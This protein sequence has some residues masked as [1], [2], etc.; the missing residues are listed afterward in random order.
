MERAAHK[1]IAVVLALAPLLGLAQEPARP[2][3]KSHQGPTSGTTVR[4]VP[5]TRSAESLAAAEIAEAEAAMEK[6]DFAAAENA[7]K[8]AVGHDPKNYRAWFDYGLLYTSTERNGEAIEAY[9]KSIAQNPK[10][11]ESNFNLGVLLTR[12]NDPAAE[13]YLRAATQLTPN[14]G[15]RD[16]AWFRSWMTLGHLLETSKPREAIDAFDHAAGLNPKDVSARLYAGAIAEKTGDM[17]IAE[18]EYAAAQQINPN[19]PQ[20]SAG[21]ANVLIATGRGDQAEEAIR[22]YIA[23]L[24]KQGAN[25]E[26]A[27][28]HVELGHLLLQLHRRDEAIT[29]FE[30]A[31]KL[32]PGNVKAQHELAWMYL[33]D[34]QYAKAET[35]FRQLLQASPKDAELRAGLGESL[36]PQKKFAEAQQELIAALQIKPDMVDAYSDLAFAASE[37]K[38]YE[39]AVKALDARTKLAKDT[40][41]TMF[42]RATALDHLGDRKNAVDS[43]REFLALSNGKFPDQEWQ[44]RHRIVAIQPKK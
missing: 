15:K 26:L 20:A 19:D 10:L 9:K 43:Y 44:A 42:L 36:I 34:K 37:N 33:Q 14:M 3:P 35:S 27:S 30:E 2:A 23:T 39:L 16:D 32:S 6:K 21:M 24:P 1:A 12:G 25:N 17:A 18:K 40:A 4:K 13:S 8:R 41:G 7:L 38:N 29:E 5:A 11:F 28:A 31:D 22:K